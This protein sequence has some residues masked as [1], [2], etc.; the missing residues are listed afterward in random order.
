MKTG[1]FFLVI[2]AFALLAQPVI[3]SPKSINV[4]IA[5]LN[6]SGETGTAKLTQTD[7]GVQVDVN[8]K[9]APADAQP[10]HVHAGSAC[11]NINPAP[12]Y[13]VKDLVDGKSSTVIPNIKLADIA[14]GKHAINIHK[15]AADLPTYVACGVIPA[16]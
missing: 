7:A 4:K 14:D 5:A 6:G 1:S 9:G 15:S 10:T 8:I 3:A 12:E 11:A 13:P 2:T 16:K